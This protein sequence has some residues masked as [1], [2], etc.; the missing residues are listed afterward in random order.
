M[1]D[2][3]STIPG[4]E[5]STP[6]GAD[7]GEVRADAVAQVSIY[8]KAPDAHRARPDRSFRT[9]SEMRAERENSLKDQIARLQTFADGEG[10]KVVETDSG[11]RLVKVEGTLRQRCRRLSGRSCADT[12]TRDA[13]S[14]PGLAL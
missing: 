12:N 7:A 1:A 2:Q 6:P 13:P 10:L 14:G 11:R 3:R 4:S 8:L 9:R 5:R